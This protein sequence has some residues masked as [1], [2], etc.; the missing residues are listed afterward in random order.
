METRNLSNE[1]N[2]QQPL[3]ENKSVGN[4]QATEKKAETKK[5]KNKKK[6]RSALDVAAA[7]GRSAVQHAHSHIITNKPGDF[8]HSGTNISYDN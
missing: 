4:E 3:Q 7:A 8:A 2:E 6:H 5:E 1:G